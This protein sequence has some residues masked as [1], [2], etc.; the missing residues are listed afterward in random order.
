M[1][2]PDVAGIY[3]ALA[4]LPHLPAA[5]RACY[6]RQASTARVAKALHDGHRY[7]TRALPRRPGVARVLQPRDELGRFCRRREA[8]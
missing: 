7:V 5:E 1:S 2:T 4:R 3:T 6:R 8:A